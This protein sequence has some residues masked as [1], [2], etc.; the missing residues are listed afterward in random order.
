M[1]DAESYSEIVSMMPQDTM[2]EML[3]TLFEPPEG[4]VHVLLRALEGSD[5]ADIG[6]NAHKLKGTAMLLGFLSIVKTSAHIEHIATQ[7]GEDLPPDISD[8]LLRDVAVTQQA[9]RDFEASQP[10]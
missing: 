6:Y 8:Q 9:L 1:I 3:A 4:T 10:S 5:R 2:D 7:T